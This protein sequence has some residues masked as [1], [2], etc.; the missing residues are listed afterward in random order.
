MEPKILIAD[1][2]RELAERFQ[3]YLARYGY[4]VLTASGGVECLSMI[5]N[6]PPAVIVVSVDLLWGGADGLMDCLQDESG[7]RRGPSVI[8]TGGTAEEN[9]AELCEQPCVIRYLRKPFLIVRL[10]DCIH[11][12]E[13]D[14]RGD[15][16]LRIS[17]RP[18]LAA[19]ACS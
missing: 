14:A 10:L 1:D 13:S 16:P 15:E 4:R 19:A 18:R 12:I 3:C 2:D 8:L 9:V 17:T 7:Q 11:A 6:D 5:R